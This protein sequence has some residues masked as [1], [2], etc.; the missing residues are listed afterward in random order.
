M[1]TGCISGMLP[2]VPDVPIA[3]L[4]SGSGSNLRRIL[5]EQSQRA[6]RV[7]VVIADRDAPGLRH[8]QA[9]GVP[10]EVVAWNG[11]RDSFTKRVC[12]RIDSHGCQWVVL[13]G[14]M[15]VLAP[16]AVERFPNR[17]INIHPSLLPAF[18]GAHAVEAALSAG[19]K[20]SGVTVHFVVEQV[21]AG[22]IIAQRAVPVL[23]G[24]NQDTLHAR[25]QV[26]EHDLYPKV[27]HALAQ[28]D[29]T[30]NDKEV[31]WS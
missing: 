29:I 13:A 7:S 19:V 16:V 26:E 21:D 9:F 23:E 15:R 2:A 14:F 17:I 4:I 10:I 27:I 1:G 25:I 8:A 31:K 20:E 12:D 30:V 28:G 24:D 6:Y 18:P 22:P 11:D 3:V 5:D